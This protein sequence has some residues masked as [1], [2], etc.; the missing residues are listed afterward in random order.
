MVAGIFAGHGVFAGTCKE[1]DSKNA[2]GFFEHV[3]FTRLVLDLYGRGKISRGE[4]VRPHPGFKRK[5]LALLEEDGYEKG[6]WMIKHA[7]VYYRIWDDFEPQFVL[8]R[9]NTESI[10][11]SAKALGWKTRHI[12]QGQ[13]LLNSLAEELKAPQVMS[14]ELIDGNY[15][16]LCKAFDHCGLDFDEKIAAAFIDRSLWKHGVKSLDDDDSV[17]MRDKSYLKPNWKKGQKHA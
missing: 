16:S 15:E 7:H 9:R 11:D 14:N 13:R 17:V 10:T 6:P 1:A 3:G 4:L 2:K 5:M 8:V 12:I